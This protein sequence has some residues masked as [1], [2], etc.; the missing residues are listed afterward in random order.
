MRAGLWRQFGSFDNLFSYV[1]FEFTQFGLELRVFGNPTVIWPAACTVHNLLF[2]LSL[3]RHLGDPRR[4]ELWVFEHYSSYYIDYLHC[5]LQLLACS[6][7]CVALL[8]FEKTLNFVNFSSVL[9]LSVSS[10]AYSTSCL[11]LPFCFTWNFATNVLG[12]EPPSNNSHFTFFKL[13]WW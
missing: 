6:F 8:S 7:S 2:G 13:K 12:L 5:S 10:T 1:W 11:D 3:V 4:E 9:L